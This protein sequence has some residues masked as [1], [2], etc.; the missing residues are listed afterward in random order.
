[1]N[2]EKRQMEDASKYAGTLQGSFPVD[3]S[4]AFAQWRT[5]VP[6]VKVNKPFSFSCLKRIHK[7]CQDDYAYDR[8]KQLFSYLFTSVVMYMI[9]WLS[10][11]FLVRNDLFWGAVMA[12]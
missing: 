12:Y 2:A 11:M 1:M 3:V 9:P 8:I 5:T 7:Y 6:I 4:E 10:E